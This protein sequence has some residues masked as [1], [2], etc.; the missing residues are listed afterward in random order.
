MNQNLSSY[1]I[2]YTV[3]NTGNISKAAKELYISQ[4]AISKSIQKLEESVGCK[5][6]SRSSRGVVLTDEGKL[7][8]EHV[9]EA[10]ET[11]TMGEEKLKRSIELG[12][13]HLKIGVSSTLCKY[14]LLPYLKEFIR[15]NPHISISISCQSTNDTLK[16]L[17][18]NKIDI[19]LIGK[20]ENLKN[21]HF[22]FLEEIE[23]IFV[24]A[25]DYLRNLK[26][27]GIQKDHILQS[28]TLMLLDKNNMTRQYI[29]DYLQENQIIIKDSI[30]ISDMDLLIDFA[31]IG[32]GVACVI[33]N[34]VREDLENGTLVEIPLGFP[35]HKREVGFAYKTTTKPSKSLAEFI[36]F[37]KTYR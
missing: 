9:S 11:L 14:L 22:D 17:E 1:R 6:F 2:F 18:D 10:F 19:G 5:L 12:V 31:R 16:L 30:D 32:V 28:S 7:L 13:G 34:F 3:A 36:H 25:K 35:I 26:A 24:A 15:Q 20:P 33:K 29:D 8:Y 4:P 23:D 27:R 21:I 37:Y